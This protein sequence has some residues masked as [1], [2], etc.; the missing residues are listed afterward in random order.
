MINILLLKKKL[1]EQVG[2]AEAANKD[3]VAATH[4]KDKKQAAK[5]QKSR[6]NQVGSVFNLDSNDKEDENND[7][8]P[9]LNNKRKKQRTSKQGRLGGTSVG[10]LGASTGGPYTSGSTY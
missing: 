5:M 7:N 10:Q 4:E 9:L 3:K 8:P 6:K 1:P 2:E